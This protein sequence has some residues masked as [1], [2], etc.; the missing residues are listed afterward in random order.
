MEKLKNEEG[1]YT[2]MNAEEREAFLDEMDGELETFEAEL[3]AAWYTANKP[4]AGEA[5]SACVS[6]KCTGTNQCCGTSTAG[7]DKT[8]NL[9]VDKTTLAWTDGL[10]VAYTHVCGAQKLMA[11]FTA[12]FAAAYLM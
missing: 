7:S 4:A 2:E 12:T 8:E 6:K 10:G 1:Y 3:T 11:A 5:G 9:C